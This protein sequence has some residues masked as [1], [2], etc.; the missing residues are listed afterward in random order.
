M[1]K[2][3][4]DQFKKLGSGGDY[5]EWY[6]QMECYFKGKGFWEHV[7]NNAA[8]VIPEDSNETAEM[9]PTSVKRL[10]W[11]LYIQIFLKL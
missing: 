10:L 9:K 6:A 7:R 3:R 8:L 2:N 1:N 11:T 5:Y 4:K